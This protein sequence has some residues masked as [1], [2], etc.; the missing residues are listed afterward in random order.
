MFQSPK[1]DWK[2]QRNDWKGSEGVVLLN[3]LGSN[4]L[5]ALLL[6][7]DVEFY[8]LRGC[9]VVIFLNPDGMD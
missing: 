8:D 6:S 3:F 2:R 1:R 4:Y 5:E 9:A 7:V